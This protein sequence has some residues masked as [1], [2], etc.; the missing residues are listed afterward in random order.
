MP[1]HELYYFNEFFLAS[2]YFALNSNNWISVV[3]VIK[4]SYKITSIIVFV[5]HLQ[6]LLDYPANL[7]WI[8]LPRFRCRHE[9]P[10][11]QLA[12]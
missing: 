11:P 9:P 1:L 12:C 2:N 8:L 3:E 6:N 5:S 10:S 4:R 7:I